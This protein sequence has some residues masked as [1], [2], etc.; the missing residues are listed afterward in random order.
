MKID[1]D[2]SDPD[3][4]GFWAIDCQILEEDKPKKTTLKFR[5]TQAVELKSATGLEPLEAHQEKTIETDDYGQV[6]LLLRPQRREEG[7]EATMTIN[8]L[9]VRKKACLFSVPD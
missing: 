8:A 6:T 2:L 7:I 5:V 9:G 3:S 4:N 1:L